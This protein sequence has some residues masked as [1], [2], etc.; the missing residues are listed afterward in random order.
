MELSVK[1]GSGLL[2]FS[3]FP[4]TLFTIIL[5]HAKC[6]QVQNTWGIWAQQQITLDFM[7]IF[8]QNKCM[9]HWQ[10]K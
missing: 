8:E 10:C 7:M 6:L 5:N 4:L 3:E 1:H 2:L 9:E